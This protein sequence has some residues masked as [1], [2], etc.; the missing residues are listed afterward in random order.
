MKNTERTY[1]IGR[2]DRER[3]DREHNPNGISIIMAQV[4]TPFVRIDKTFKYTD[5][6]DIENGV[7]LF[8]TTGFRTITSKGIKLDLQLV[9]PVKKIGAPEDD[10]WMPYYLKDALSKYP[11]DKN[12]I[13]E[14]N[15]SD[16]HLVMRIYEK[17]FDE[18]SQFGHTPI[19]EKKFLEWLFNHLSENEDSVKE[20]KSIIDDYKSNVWDGDT[21]EV[22]EFDPHYDKLCPKF[23][24]SFSNNRR[25]S[26]N[27]EYVELTSSDIGSKMKSVFIESDED[28]DKYRPYFRDGLE[29]VR[30]PNGYMAYYKIP[31]RGSEEYWEILKK[32][33]VQDGFGEF[34]IN[35]DEMGIGSSISITTPC[36]KEQIYHY[37]TDVYSDYLKLIGVR[38]ERSIEVLDD[39]FEIRGDLNRTLFPQSLVYIKYHNKYG[40]FK[41]LYKASQIFLL[42]GKCLN[43]YIR[44][45]GSTIDSLRI[46]FEKKG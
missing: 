19:G 4:D 23:I 2:F 16:I 36:G 42:K 29:I 26:S 7:Y 30:G 31:E 21:A 24:P 1:L 28:I 27:T 39:D 17:R 8:K 12:V 32:S 11:Y 38:K 43:A 34:T 41:G 14:W 15:R 40:N 18:I 22:M 44:K 6:T 45:I 10:L 35:S 46:I 5:F 13:C 3:N 33:E 9:I 25:Y 37:G 20:M